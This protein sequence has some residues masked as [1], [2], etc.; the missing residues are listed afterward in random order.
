M[1]NVSD[2]ILEVLDV[3]QESIKL[4]SPED[5]VKLEDINKIRDYI[6]QIEEE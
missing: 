3:M 2:K 4:N 5:V 1:E 6:N